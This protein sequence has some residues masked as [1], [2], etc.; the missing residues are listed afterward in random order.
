MRE[1]REQWER[2]GWIEDREPEIRAQGLGIGDY[3]LITSP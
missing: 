3:P 2:D 1:Q